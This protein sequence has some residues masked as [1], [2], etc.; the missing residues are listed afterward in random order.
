MQLN[1]TPQT[2]SCLVYVW[3]PRLD[4]WIPVKEKENHIVV[5][6]LHPDMSSPDTLVMNLTLVIKA[7]RIPERGGVYDD[8]YLGAVNAGISFAALNG[9]VKAPTGEETLEVENETT[10]EYTQQSN[11]T[12]A[13]SAKLKGREAKLGSASIEKGY[14]KEFKTKY[15]SVERT[16]SVAK[17]SDYVQWMFDPMA[18]GRAGREYIHGN[19]YLSSEAEWPNGDKRGRVTVTWDIELFDKNG[20]PFYPENMWAALMALRKGGLRNLLRKHRKKN[21]L[22][23]RFTVDVASTATHA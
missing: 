3:P 2:P 18:A 1:N 17:H 11:A 6:D 21:V 4:R 5:L 7:I 20:K 10:T 8:F 14:K 13:P 12:L 19:V 22:G 9:T 15:K 16:L 23:I